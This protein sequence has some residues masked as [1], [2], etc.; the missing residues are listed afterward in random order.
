MDEEHVASKESL[1][2][3]SKFVKRSVEEESSGGT[4]D[5]DLKAVEK[6]VEKSNSLSAKSSLPPVMKKRIIKSVAK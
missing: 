3:E 5:M 6:S 2:E 1:S 4:S